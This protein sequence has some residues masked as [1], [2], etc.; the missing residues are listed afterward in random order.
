MPPDQYQL[1]GSA[2]RIY[3]DQK[4]RAIFA[5]L[6]RATLDVVPLATGDKL[7]D[8]ACGTGIVARS[9]RDRYGPGVAVTG[10]DLNDS[11]IEMARRLTSS[12]VPPIEWVV[13]DATNMPFEDEA[14]SICICQQGVQFIPDK[15]AAVREFRRVLKPGGRVAI[16]VWAGASAFFVAMADALGRHVGEAVAEQSLAPFAFRAE[17]TVPGLLSDSGFGEVSVQA[18]S[19]D[20]IIGDPETAI[21]KEI[22]GNP[23]GPK[24]KEKGEEV[25]GRIVADII[26]DCARF[27]VK[28]ALVV[29]Q[30]AHLFTATATG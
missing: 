13:A 4:V 16:S 23:V 14:F 24:V 25:L 2:A 27:E 28:G 1:V 8:V 30:K 26:R 6:A 11:M 5:P 22:F 10:A 21:P 19:I 15:M 29:P 7:L 9:V 20:R 12:V 17:E 3:E 18:L